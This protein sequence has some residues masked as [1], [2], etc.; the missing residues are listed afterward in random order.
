MDSRN[1]LLETIIR[2]ALAAKASDIL[3]ARNSIAY[4][5][6]GEVT[7]TTHRADDDFIEAIL[8]AQYDPENVERARAAV[9]GPEGA[10]DVAITVGG[11]RLRAN[12]YRWHGGLGAALRPLPQFTPDAEAL[13]IPSHILE[14]ILRTRR[15]LV[16]VN[17]PTSSGKSTTLNCLV[18]CINV[19][20]TD[21]IISIEEP[22]EYLYQPKRS[23]I[24]QRE[25]G[26]HVRSFSEALR[27][28]LRQNPNVIVVGEVRDPETVQ[29]ALQGAETG[30]L[31][32]GTLH[33]SN[34][35]DTVS[36]L[37]NLMPDAREREVRTA[38][39]ASLRL[40]IC[41]RLYKRA[42]ESGRVAAREILINNTAIAALIRDGKDHQIS[43]AL[44]THRK[45]GMVDWGS[46]LKALRDDGAI[47]R[48]TWASENDAT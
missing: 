38:L 39:A 21:N 33:T 34:A 14:L 13:G 30:H 37:V 3:I 8:A 47:T 12:V 19:H 31:V 29:A 11:H 48:E 9:R 43:S 35:S 24:Q 4:R 1:L 45:D 44:S 25:V 18:E 5:V 36:R 40:I 27:A 46:A 22:I 10:A 2:E 6:N 42:D 7:P 20:R 16:L 28:A 26:K 23:T 15:G 32:F 17:G 41:Q